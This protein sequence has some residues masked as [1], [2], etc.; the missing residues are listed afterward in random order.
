MEGFGE[1]LELTAAGTVPE[2]DRIPFYRYNES[3][4]DTKISCKS[5]N[6]FETEQM[7][8]TDFTNNFSIIFPRY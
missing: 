6:I 8:Y 7:E 4:F 5:R 3:Y 2:F 1:A